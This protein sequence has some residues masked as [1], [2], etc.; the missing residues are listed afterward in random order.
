MKKGLQTFLLG[1]ALEVR[2]RL[3]RRGLEDYYR[4][5]PKPPKRKDQVNAVTRAIE[6]LIDRGCL[7]GFGVRTRKKWF[8]KEVRLTAFGR[9]RAIEILGGQPALPLKSK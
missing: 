4:G 1:K 6:L 8:I 5:V 3:A 9:R 2:G 7:T